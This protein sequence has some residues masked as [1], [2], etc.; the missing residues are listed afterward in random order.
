LDEP[1]RDPVEDD[2]ILPVLERRLGRF[3]AR[4]R[5]RIEQDHEARV[6]GYGLNF[7]HPENWYAAH[8][9]IALALKVTGLYWRRRRNA[10]KAERRHNT[11]RSR[12][13]PASFDGFAILQL[14]DLHVDTNPRAMARVAELVRGARYDISVLT[15]DFRGRTFGN[16]EA[17]LFGLGR[18]REYLVGEVFAVLGNRDTIR[19]L[20]GMEAL[21]IRVLVNESVQLERGG[22]RIHLVGVDDAHYFRMDNIEKA[23]A[24]VPSGEFAILLSHT[25][26]IYRQAAYADFKLMLSGHTHGGQI[27]LPGSIPI[28]LDSRLPRR[29]GSGAWMYHRMPGDTSAGVGMSIVPVRINCPAE[30]TIHTLYSRQTR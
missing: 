17:T 15:G 3:Y 11:V 29:L 8:Y 1:R 30:I 22:G 4:Q 5:L 7:F 21:G 10:G 23:T 16:Y 9:L 19:M 25:P 28:T 6:F 26:E 12:D 2:A 13:L 27:C 20:P 14:S 24:G 18:I